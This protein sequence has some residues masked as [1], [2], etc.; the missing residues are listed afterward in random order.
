MALWAALVA[1]TPATALAHPD[2][3]FV[4][5]EIDRLVAANPADPQL[6]IDQA[7]MRKRAHDWDGALVSLARALALGAD[8]DA[9]AAARGGVFL[10]AGFPKMAKLEYDA[11]LAHRPDAADALFERGRVLLALGEFDGADRDF[12]RAIAIMPAPRPEHVAL[13]AETL[14]SRGR[15]E[16]AVRALDDGMARLGA[17]PSLALTA[18]DLDVELH[19]YASALAR[20]DA[21]LRQAPA[22]A[23]WITRRA[24]ILKQANRTDEARAEFA[25]ALQQIE[26]RPA[27]RQNPASRA[28]AERLR[29]EL[30]ADAPHPEGQL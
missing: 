16:D 27:Q 17:L 4:A 18:V 24:E 2:G 12:A 22:N 11:V 3:D 5:A 29:S 21:L 9:V 30:A 26:A 23:A 10:A 6:L 28:L 19:R 20:L 13:R 15:R 25:R 14:R 7:L 1:A 8:A